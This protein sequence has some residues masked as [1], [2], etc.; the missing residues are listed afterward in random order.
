MCGDGA[1][2]CGALKAAHVGISL[3]EAESSVA[4]PLTSK[5]DNISC[6][7]LVIREGR[8]ALVTSF[9][10]FK[11]MLCYSLTEFTSVIILYGID[12]NLTSIQFLFI[13]IFLVLNFASLFGKTE[14]YTGK[15]F[16]TPPMTSLL[17]FV[18]LASIITHMLVIVAFQVGVYHM[19]QGYEWFVPFQYDPNNPLKYNSYENYAIYSLSMF[20]YIASAIVFS[21]GVPYRKPLYTNKL[22]SFSLLA[23]TIVCAYMTL[24]PADWI[25]QLFEIKL[26]PHFD[27]RPMILLLAAVNL[28]CCLLMEECVVE[29]FLN[30]TLGPRCGKFKKKRCKT[31]EIGDDDCAWSIVDCD[32]KT[33]IYR[34]TDE[35]GSKANGNGLQNPGFG[36]ESVRESVTTKV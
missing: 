29:M 34:E 33:V 5:R 15:L 6:V 30:K 31:K 20:E 35:L 12:A 14:A 11:F 17:S 25:L 16:P 1:N 22:F 28:V 8:A 18:P 32:M 23:M 24:Y 10:V 27:V 2:D 19:I 4:S 36:K 3:S 26:P 7:P 13:D 9:G 21:R